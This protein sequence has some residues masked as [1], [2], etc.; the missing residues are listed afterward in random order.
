MSH[1]RSLGD[2]G[3]DIACAYLVEKGY[4]IH[5]RQ[6]RSKFGEVDIIAEKNGV[7]V[8]VEVKTRASNAF[9]YPEEAVTLSKR[10][11]LLRTVELYQQMKRLTVPCRIDVLAITLHPNSGNAVLHFEDIT[12]A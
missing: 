6:W 7:F 4:R 3:E 11:H 2:R 8:F 5:E 1:N 9:G 10:Q 12:G